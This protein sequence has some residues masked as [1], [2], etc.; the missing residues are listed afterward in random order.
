MQVNFV[1]DHELIRIAMRSVV[2]RL[3]VQEPR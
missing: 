3:A 2:E 1:D